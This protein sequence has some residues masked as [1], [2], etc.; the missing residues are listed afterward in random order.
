MQPKMELDPS[1]LPPALTFVL[2]A[3]LLLCDGFS[4]ILYV[5]LEPVS[6]LHIPSSV[7]QGN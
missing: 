1:P 2:P 7:M 5:L 3:L 6:T 4:L